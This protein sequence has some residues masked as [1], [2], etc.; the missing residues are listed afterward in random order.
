MATL[1]ISEFGGF[2]SI[3]TQYGPVAPQPA[4]ADQ[5]VAIGASSAQSAA[6]N[7]ITHLVMLSSDA[8]CS[9]LFG[10]NPTAAATN[11]RIPANVPLLFSVEPGQKVAV[12]TNS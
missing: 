8:V 2:A 7:A 1:Y 12:I 10:A 4:V 11:L 6:F 9:V 3:G 5:H